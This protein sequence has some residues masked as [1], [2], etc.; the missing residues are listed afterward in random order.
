MPEPEITSAPLESIL[1]RA[2]DASQERS[3]TSEA[4]RQQMYDEAK[5]RAIEITEQKLQTVTTRDDWVVV[6]DVPTMR[7]A[8]VLELSPLVRIV[9]PKLG[10]DLMLRI[11]EDPLRWPTIRDLA[12][13]GDLIAEYGLR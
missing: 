1:A 11:G 8:L 2:L 12:H 5:D 9:L 10:S 4:L 3:G 6:T 13:L 7:M